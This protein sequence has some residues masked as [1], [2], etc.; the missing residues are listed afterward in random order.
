[1]TGPLFEFLPPTQAERPYTVSE[2]NEG[3]A[4]LLESVN[5]LVWVEGEISNWRVAGSGHCYFHLK[6]AECQIPAVLWRSSAEKLAFVPDNGLSVTAIASIRVYRKAGYY[7]LDIHRMEPRGKGALFVA[8]EQ[9]KRK[10]EREG[11]FD[12]AHKRP[13][14]ASIRRL[15]IVTSKQGAA[16]R[17]IVRVTVSRAPQ[18]DI[19]LIDVPVQGETAAPKIAAA[20]NDMNAYAGVDCIIVGRGGGSAED[21]W[22]FNE[23]IVARAIYDSQIAVISAVG[24]E[25]DFTIADFVADLRAPTPSAAA[26]MAV[27]DRAES[28]RYLDACASR[29]AAGA[30]RYFSDVNERFSADAS[31][32]SLKLP[33]QRLLE[34]EQALDGNTE[35]LVHRFNG[36]LNTMTLRF[37]TASSRLHAYSPLGV[38]TRGYSVVTTGD[39][40]VVRDAGIL[41]QGQN[42]AMR[43]HKG[44]ATAKVTTVLPA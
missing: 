9:L 38:L 31:H 5:S 2:I 30:A 24:H 22:P 20:I 1:M 16:L 29:F 7:Q 36:L 17:D 3:I 26:E 35:M 42:V 40:Q 37:S 6:D 33:F 12:P 43:F 41:T 21:L 27:P 13:L 34:H 25:T 32:R 11:L 23:E 10:L 14:P 15:G 8:F 19:V 18:T 28:R 4:V 39:G 44:S